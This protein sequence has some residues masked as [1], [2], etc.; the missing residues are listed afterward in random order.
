VA[1]FQSIEVNP[2]EEHRCPEI[3][4]ASRTEK[5]LH[6]RFYIFGPA[7]LEMQKFAF[8]ENPC[9]TLQ[10][11][12]GVREMGET[13]QVEILTGGNTFLTGNLSTAAYIMNSAV[14]VVIED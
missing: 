2:P 4:D 9:Y 1:E 11:P 10:R 12:G 6:P 5:S 13:S 3:L 7:C 14:A 8:P